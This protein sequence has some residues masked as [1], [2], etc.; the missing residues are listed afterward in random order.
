[1]QNVDDTKQGLLPLQNCLEVWSESK[2][3]PLF[4]TRTLCLQRRWVRFGWQKEQTPR[5][6]LR[7]GQKTGRNIEQVLYSQTHTHTESVQCTHRLFFNTMQV[8]EK[9]GR[10]AAWLSWFF[11]LGQQVCLK[12]MQQQKNPVLKSPVSSQKRLPIQNTSLLLELDGAQWRNS[13]EC[14]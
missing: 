7:P 11:L 12:W 4:R 9:R 8:Q 3:L 5:T 1:M 10:T 2:E 14:W 6:V 13:S